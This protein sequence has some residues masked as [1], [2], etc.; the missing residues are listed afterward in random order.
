L[1]KCPYCAELIQDEAIFCRYCQ[2]DIPPSQ[3]KNPQPLVDPALNNSNTYIYKLDFEKI[4][5]IGKLDIHDVRILGTLAFESYAFP[6]SL[7]K[8]LTELKNYFI[9]DRLVPVLKYYSLMIMGNH[10]E[11]YINYC[12]DLFDAWALVILGLRTEITNGD[13]PVK[14]KRTI[15]FE[16]T[17]DILSMF[18]SKATE[19]ELS[20]GLIDNSTLWDITTSQFN[21]LSPLMSSLAFE[22]KQLAVLESKAISKIK[23]VHG[24]TPFC[25]EVKRLI[26]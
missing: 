7:I 8:K 10:K 14:W 9:F 24:E 19:I 4:S 25:L 5:K 26:M 21:R 13:L 20:F 16:C 15:T 22:I 11:E 18:S 3:S 12:S 6:D 2:R 17:E 23:L 1:K